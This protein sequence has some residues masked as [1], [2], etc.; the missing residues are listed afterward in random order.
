MEKR[1]RQ[2]R[3]KREMVNYMNVPVIIPTYNPTDRIFTVV[4]GL[5]SAGFE[6][7]V[8]IDDGSRGACG[9]IFTK[10]SEIPQCIV[11]H[12]GVNRGKGRGLKTGFTYVLEHLPE[13]DGV[14]TTDD[15]GQHDPSDILRCAQKMSETGRAVLGARDFTGSDVPP[16]SRFGN[17][18]TRIVFR[19]LCGIKITDTQ[20]GL[21]ALPLKYLK[22]LS[23]L[24][25]ERFEYETNML[26]EMKRL[27]LPFD[28]LK[29]RTIYDDKN[30]GTHF[31]PLTD[32]IRIYAVIFRFMLSSGIC[33]LIDIG[34]FTLLNLILSQISSLDEGVRIF[35]ATAGARVVSSL[36]NFLINR[37]RVFRSGKNAKRSALRY[38]ILCAAQLT[39][40][41]LCVRG[42][43]ALF[44]AEAGLWQSVIKIV[45]DTLLFF[46][47]F[48][49]QRD[50]VYKD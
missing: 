40:S 23:E 31:N 24:G 26:L 42:I 9:V 46:I 8:I 37:N 11:L 21:R 48:G 32:S 18:A 13:C 34:L 44:C 19:L 49:I 3:L 28:E 2:F 25:G 39:V 33:S 16:K 47:S 1:N 38:Y 29:I 43:S 50:W 35:I 36:V 12:H 15:D 30:K 5:I 4:H 10:L 27:S 17:N 7:I 14:V 20:T 22:P 41:A 45:T 6:K